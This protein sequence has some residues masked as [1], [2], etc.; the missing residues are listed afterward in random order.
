MAEVIMLWTPALSVRHR[1]RGEKTSYNHLQKIIS[2]LS[3][4][5]TIEA[6]LC[7]YWRR[8]KTD[9]RADQ[10]TGSWLRHPANSQLFVLKRKEYLYNFWRT[11]VLRCLYLSINSVAIALFLHCI[12]PIMPN[13]ENVLPW[14]HKAVE[15]PNRSRVCNYRSLAH[16]VPVNEC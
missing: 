11:S 14:L 4:C 6:I 10:R 3:V 8:G 1:V 2:I 5:L 9:W 12:I 13:F 7:V 15:S 16:N